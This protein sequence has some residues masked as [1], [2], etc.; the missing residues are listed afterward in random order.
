GGALPERPI[1][2]DQPKNPYY[3][4]KRAFILG[5]LKLHHLVDA[6]VWHLFDLDH[7]P[8]EKVDLALTEPA[9]LQEIRRVYSSFVATIPAVAPSA[10]EPEA[11]KEE[12][13]G[14]GADQDEQN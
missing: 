6:N 5:G 4:T 7:D 13:A 9:R 12:G 8:A 2:I 10:P 3:D 11:R 14:G 1:L